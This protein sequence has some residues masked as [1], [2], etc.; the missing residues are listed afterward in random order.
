[1]KKLEA[2]VRPIAFGAV[3]AVE[4]AIVVDDA[5]AARACDA[6]VS[7]TRGET[8]GVGKILISHID[9]AIDLTADDPIGVVANSTVGACTTL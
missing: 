3:P 8:L 2:T 9:E 6:I 1:M 5:M 4:I 7:A